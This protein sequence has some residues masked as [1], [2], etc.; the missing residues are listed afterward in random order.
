M[1]ISIV[2]VQLGSDPTPARPRTYLSSHKK[3]PYRPPICR[4][5]RCTRPLRKAQRGFCSD[6][7]ALQFFEQLAD[8]TQLVHEWFHTRWPLSP[9][10]RAPMPEVFREL[11]TAVTAARKLVESLVTPENARAVNPEPPRAGAVVRPRAREL[12]RTAVK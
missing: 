7:C 8:E 3:A 9:T 1:T 10:M 12:R 5:R 2:K 11:R 6:A 4:R